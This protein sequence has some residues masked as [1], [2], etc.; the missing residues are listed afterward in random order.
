MEV[1]V[2][3]GTGF[4]GS[5]VVEYLLELGHSVKCLIRRS[6]NLQW[7]ETLPVKLVQADFYNIPSL[8][9]AAEG[10]D[11]IIHVAGVVASKD[12]K[13]F[14]EGNQLATRNL[15]DA[16]AEAAPGLQRF[17]HVSSQTAIGPS[18]NG[19]P[20]DT[21]TEP[22]PI[23]T[24]GESKLAA[25][26][27]VLRFADKI[28]VTITRPSA[29]YGPRDTATL[30]FFQSVQ[31]GIIPLIGYSTKKVSLIHVA[32][33]RRGIVDA[34]FSM[35]TI[36]KSYFIGSEQVYTWGE[37]GKVTAEVVGKRTRT[38]RVPEFLVMG[39]AGVSGLFNHLSK[40]PSVLNFEKGKD[41]IQAAWTCSIETARR[42]FSFRQQIS[43]EDG[44]RNTIAWYREMGWL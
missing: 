2:T 43:L 3:G 44:I 26:K 20:V 35:K 29:V 25:E 39:I 27:E 34:A 24:Y 22:R 42:D 41:M 8:R 10:V 7:L 32:D 17:L 14:F 15:L 9:T 13:G 30:T 28:P 19:N 37:I 31:K 5:F 16:A 38:L 21:H 40:K 1:L 4:I 6:S 23:T 11:V 12:R 33:L 18:R 36:G